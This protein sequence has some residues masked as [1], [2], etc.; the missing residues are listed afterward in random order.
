M[1]I[2]ANVVD[3][4]LDYTY[5]DSSSKTSSGSDLGYDQFLQLLCAEMQYQDPLEPSSNTD[6]VAQLATFSQVEATLN[7]SE[8]QQNS[9]ASTLVGK[10]VILAVPDNSGNTNYVTGNV[11]YV[12]YQNGT[13]YL[14]V[15]D[16]LYPFE[17][18]DT[19]ADSGYY[20]AV[21]LSKTFSTMVST[22]PGK[23]KITAEYEGA[24]QEVRDLYDG[25]TAY[26]QNFVSSDDLSTFEAIETRVKELVAAKNAAGSAE[27]TTD[28]ENGTGE[29]TEAVDEEL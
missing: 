1:A 6:Y 13:P 15:N 17:D 10:E 3:G 26:Q 14:S 18:L 9:F 2:T 21:S 19:I 16:S 25:M 11:D 20:E 29:E 4:T 7:I 23:D 24:V 28:T 27:E 5:T 12:V 22:L 8:S